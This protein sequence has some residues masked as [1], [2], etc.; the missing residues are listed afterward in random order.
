[1]KSDS[2]QFW[3]LLFLAGNMN[4]KTIQKQRSKADHRIIECLELEGTLKIQSF[5]PYFHA[6]E[7]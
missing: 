7:H 2:S 4:E 3:N 5:T 1:M 6:W